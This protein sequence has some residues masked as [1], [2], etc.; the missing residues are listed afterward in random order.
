MYFNFENDLE[1]L[2]NSSLI[3]ILIKQM[4]N[5]K[6]HELF[7]NYIVRKCNNEK[8]I[9]GLIYNYYNN[10]NKYLKKRIIY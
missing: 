6:M 7:R 8:D 2:E 4:Q 9:M 1:E 3:E 5:I 10:D